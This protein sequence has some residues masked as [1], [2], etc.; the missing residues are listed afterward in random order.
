M[1]LFIYHNANSFHILHYTMLLHFIII[2]RYELY[3]AKNQYWFQLGFV[4]KY[5]LAQEQFQY[6]N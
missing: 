4:I 1:L 2:L 3:L 5:K 6:K